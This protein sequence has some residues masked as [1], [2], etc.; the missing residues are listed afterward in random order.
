MDIT[1]D[2]RKACIIHHTEHIFDLFLAQLSLP[3]PPLLAVLMKNDLT[4][5][6]HHT[7]TSIGRQWKFRN[8]HL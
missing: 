6:R 8:N 7:P 4:P 1:E 2:L 3:S 5:P